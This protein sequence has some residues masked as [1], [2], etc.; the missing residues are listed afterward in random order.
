MTLNQ[1]LA[2]CEAEARDVQRRDCWLPPCGER[3]AALLTMI[4]AIYGH[5]AAR[6]VSH[7]S[8]WGNSYTVAIGAAMIERRE[9]TLAEIS[10]AIDGVKSMNI[11]GDCAAKENASEKN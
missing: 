10:K 8:G 11:G 5:G 1:F 7:S 9:K 6:R 3:S 2:S 4:H